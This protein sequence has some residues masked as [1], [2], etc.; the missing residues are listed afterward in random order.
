MKPP[1]EKEID[2]YV[3]KKNDKPYLVNMLL[4]IFDKMSPESP[5][6]VGGFKRLPL[7]FYYLGGF[8]Y[9]GGWFAVF[10]YFIYSSYETYSTSS[11]VSLDNISGVCT[12][13]PIAITG[14]YKLD[15]Y[16]TWETQHS[17]KPQY[18]SMIARTSA[19]DSDSQTYSKL[20]NKFGE[21]YYNIS[22]KSMYRDLA[23]N[24][25][26]LA[27]AYTI[28]TSSGILELQ[29]TGEISYMLN[30]QYSLI[31]AVVNI[32]DLLGTNPGCF[33][34]GTNLDISTNLLTSSFS[35]SKSS[36]NCKR[37]AFDFGYDSTYGDIFYFKL[38]LASFRYVS[39]FFLCV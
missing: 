18:A 22:K 23:Y 38:D 20:I 7:F 39:Y 37:I 15:N 34:S 16:G 10:A 28:D 36:Y 9:N 31:S 11:Y 3:N 13:V 30:K 4:N 27:S 14:E 33:R 21:R 6:F 17:F 32:S 12:E 19:F 24:L 8:V 2:N 26:V 25:N 35:Y 1:M 29:P 5:F